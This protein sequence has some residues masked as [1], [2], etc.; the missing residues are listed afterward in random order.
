ME[1]VNPNLYSDCKRYEASVE[2]GK[3][4]AEFGKLGDAP[5]VIKM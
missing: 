5:R 4:G 1:L 3:K 2:N